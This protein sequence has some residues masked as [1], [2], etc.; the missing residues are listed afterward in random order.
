LARGAPIVDTLR[1]GVA[2][3]AAN[4]LTRET[5]WV[6]RGDVDAL[7]ARVETAGIV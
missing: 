1:L 4:V 7:L 5:G 3:G 6:R 2:C